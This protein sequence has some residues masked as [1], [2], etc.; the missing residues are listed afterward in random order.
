MLIRKGIFSRWM[1]EKGA[2]DTLSDGFSAVFHG[3]DAE[4]ENLR[5][6]CDALQGLL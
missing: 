3:L 1:G 5:R 4:R 2:K 6:R